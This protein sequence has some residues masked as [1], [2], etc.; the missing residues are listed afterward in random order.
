MNAVEIRQ[1]NARFRHS[2]EKKKKWLERCA[3]TIEHRC[4]NED[5]RTTKRQMAESFFSI[6][7]AQDVI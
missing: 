1:Q 6:M 7:Y 3:E 4:R 2:V 5:K